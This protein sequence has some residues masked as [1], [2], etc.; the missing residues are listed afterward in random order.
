MKAVE[1]CFPQAST[2]L[3]CQH[4]EENVRRRLQDKVGVPAEV[5]Q[6]IVRR[7]FGDEGLAGG[8]FRTTLDASGRFPDASGR[9]WTLF[10]MTGLYIPCIPYHLW[11]PV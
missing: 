7:V 5:W 6:D 10:S 8:R 4:L 11:Q 1:S 9:L 2:L 3:C